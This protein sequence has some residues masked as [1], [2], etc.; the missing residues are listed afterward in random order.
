MNRSALVLTL[1]ALGCGG[2]PPP[3]DG[4]GVVRIWN[5][6]A[7]EISY[8][9]E[10]QGLSGTILAEDSVDLELIEGTYTITAQS[11]AG[12]CYPMARSTDD[13]LN[14]TACH[15]HELFCHRYR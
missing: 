11:S 15:R 5:T 3:C 12:V 7:Q 6:T 4:V 13:E 8:Q 1:L 2:D 10:P 9:T 14:V